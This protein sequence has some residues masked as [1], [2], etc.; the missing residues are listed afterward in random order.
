MMASALATPMPTRTTGAA[1]AAGRPSGTVSFAS[2][3]LGKILVDSSGLTLYLFEADKGTS[4]C[5]SAC[6]AAWPP[7]AIS[8]KPTAGGGVNDSLL[9]TTKRCD[10]S[11]QLTYNG[12]PLFRFASDTT[13]QGVNGFGAPWDVLSPA[14]DPV[15]NQQANSGAGSGGSANPY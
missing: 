7:L 15:T 5:S 6:A 4:N 13:W 11:M 8:G 12:H 2:S 3:R 1:A 9:G 14:G 10:G